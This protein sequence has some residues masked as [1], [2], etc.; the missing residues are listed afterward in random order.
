MNVHTSGAFYEAVLTQVLGER[1]VLQKATPC[2]GGCIHRAHRLQTK[3]GEYFI[4][5]NEENALEEFKTEAEGLQTLAKQGQVRTPHV[6]GY[7][8]SQN[9]AYLLLAYLEAGQIQADAWQQLGRQLAGLHQCTH[10]AHG[11]H[12]DNYLARQPQSNPWTP[13]GADF[14]RT[15]R[16]QP[17][18]AQAH[19]LGHLSRKEMANFECLYERLPIL[20]GDEEPPALV[21]GDLWK[22]NIH[23]AQEG[24][25]ALIDPAIYYG[26]RAADWALI[27]LFGGFPPEFQQ[28]YNEIYPLPPDWEARLPLHQLYPLLIHLNL[29]GPSYLA[30]IQQILNPLLR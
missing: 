1:A 21:H 17:Q 4:K 30:S 24:Y 13:I 18:V 26:H 2:A 15:H 19:K 29:F 7:G 16:L 12:T 11:F 27:T 6:Y 23:L 3:T 25:F 22:G 5:W 9:K 10:T 14:Y 28:A 8:L 20:W